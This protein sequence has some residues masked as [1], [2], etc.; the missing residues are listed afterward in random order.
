[1]LKGQNE[2]M[3]SPARIEDHGV[4]VHLI[5]SPF[6]RGQTQIRVLL[7]EILEVGQRYPVVYVLPVEARVES[8]FGD[9]LAEIIKHDLHN[10]HRA[11]FVAPTFSA[12]PWYADHPTNQEL[13]QETYFL[14]V[15]VPLIEKMYPAQTTIEGRRLL[16][17]SKSGWGAWSMLLRHPNLFGRAAAWDSPMMLDAPGKYGSGE[18]FGTQANFEQY[19]ISKLLQIARLDDAKRLILLGRGNFQREHEQVHKLMTSLKVPHTY[20]D[21]QLRK[22]DWHSG[23]VAEAVEL[24]FVD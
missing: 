7:P 19:Q 1:M 5:V 17:F 22:H 12:L 4:R 23:W 2:T 21:G 11:I 10:K 18:I 6:Q 9:G 16:G 14:Q 3:V 20:H 24:L 15:V 13:R 8:R